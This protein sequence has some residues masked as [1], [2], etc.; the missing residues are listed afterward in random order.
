MKQS[1]LANGESGEQIQLAEW[2]FDFDYHI[3]RQTFGPL[4]VNGRIETVMV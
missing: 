2:V 4:A 3:W 1:P